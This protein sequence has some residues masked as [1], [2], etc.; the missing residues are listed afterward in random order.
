[1]PGKYYGTPSLSLLAT[2]ALEAVFVVGYLGPEFWSSTGGRRP[3]E[4]GAKAG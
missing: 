3:P 2:F 4:A 1:M